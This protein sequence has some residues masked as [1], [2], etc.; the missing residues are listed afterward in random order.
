MF[1]NNSL[2]V[3]TQPG[4]AHRHAQEEGCMSRRTDD[5]PFKSRTGEGGGVRQEP[6]ADQARRKI[7]ARAERGTSGDEGTEGTTPAHH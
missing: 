6:E 2:L 1:K 7:Q 5:D 3:Q 4:R